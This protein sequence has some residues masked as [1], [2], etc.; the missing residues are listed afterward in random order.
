MRVILFHIGDY[1]VRS[2]GLVFPEGMM[3]YST[4]GSQPLWPAEVWEGQW[5]LIVFGLLLIL[6]KSTWPK[7]FIFLAYNILYSFGRFMLE[8]L[9]GDTSRFQNKRGIGN[10]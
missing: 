8:F 10:E 7:G 4:Y 6:R 9:R 2:Y 3:A 5:N 1:P